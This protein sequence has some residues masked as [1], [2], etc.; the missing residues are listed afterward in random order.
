MSTTLDLQELC[1]VDY[2]SLEMAVELIPELSEIRIQSIGDQAAR[3]ESLWQWLK[4][5]ILR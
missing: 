5:R 4:C 1:S 2:P 3:R